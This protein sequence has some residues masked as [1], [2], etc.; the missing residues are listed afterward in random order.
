MSSLFFFCA[1]QP[2]N[3]SLISHFPVSIENILSINRVLYNILVAAYIFLCVKPHN[4]QY[5]EVRIP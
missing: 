5:I 3:Q 2:E 4:V 1:I